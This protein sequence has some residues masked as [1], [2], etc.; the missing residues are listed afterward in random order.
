[1]KKVAIVSLE[2]TQI[3]LTLATILD[4]ESF[5]VN[6]VYTE[7]T[8]IAADLASDSLIKT[9]R[10]KQC[11]CIANVIVGKSLTQDNRILRK[12][13]HVVVQEVDLNKKDNK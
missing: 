10:I 12:L 5:V 3:K 8:K 4:N 1:M 13:N 9:T 11:F 2:S 6:E 7:G